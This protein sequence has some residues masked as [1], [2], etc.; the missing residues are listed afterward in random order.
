MF[1]FINSAAKVQKK[2]DI[3]KLFCVFCPK[4]TNYH[5]LTINLFKNYFG[6][7]QMTQ[8]FG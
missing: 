5:E 2:C 6:F 4:N 1:L 7:P 8:I 3:R